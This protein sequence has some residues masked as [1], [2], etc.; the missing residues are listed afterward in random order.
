MVFFS[1]TNHQRWSPERCHPSEWSPTWTAR[2]SDYCTS[3]DFTRTPSRTGNT[4]RTAWTP[5]CQDRNRTI[6]NIACGSP[7]PTGRCS[8]CRCLAG[9]CHVAANS[10]DGAT[11]HRGTEY[12]GRCDEANRFPNSESGAPAC[13]TGGQC[14]SCCCAANCGSSSYTATTCP[15][16]RQVRYIKYSFRS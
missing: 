3:V 8:D 10:H 5:S 14:C 11:D 4:D 7:R 13:R 16:R 2:C 15:G 6:S 12:A 1:G 9:H